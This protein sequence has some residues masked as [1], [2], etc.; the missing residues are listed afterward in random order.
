MRPFLAVFIALL[1]SP[2]AAAVFDPGTLPRVSAHPGGPAYY[3]TPFYANAFRLG[4]WMEYGPNEWGSDVITNGNAQFD[5]NG[6]P[7][8]LNA[9]KKLR[10]TIWGLHV[11]SWRDA[12]GRGR[13]ELRWKGAGD[14]RL[15][16]APLAFDAAASSGAADGVLTDGRR[17]YRTSGDYAAGWIEVHAIS[18]PITDVALWLPDPAD[19]QRKSLVDQRWHPTFL[20]RLRDEPWGVIRTMGMTS[21]NGNPEQDWSDRRQPAH[22]R[23]SGVINRRNPA[24]GVVRWTESGAAEVDVE[25][26]HGCGKR[27]PCRM[28]AGWG[29]GL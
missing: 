11:G 19:P 13:L 23:A 16:G 8:Y 22:G 5:G 7:K 21:T 18:A 29:F 3:D 17:V 15:A 6:F 25:V 14:L 26:V 1:A 2:V 10:A 20:A 24:P 27:F 28:R 4:G 9:G 12:L